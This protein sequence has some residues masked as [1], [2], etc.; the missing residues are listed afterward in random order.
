MNINI[1]NTLKPTLKALSAEDEKLMRERIVSMLAKVWPELEIVA[2][3]TD[4]L[5]ALTQWKKHRPQ[6]AFLD[7]RMP[8]KTGL[9]VAAEL[10]SEDDAPHIVFV[11]AYDEYAI[12]AFE[13]DA[14]D[15]L[16]KPVESERLLATV[17]RLKKRLQLVSETPPNTAPVLAS[18]NLLG[19]LESLLNRSDGNNT[20]INLASTSAT[21][22][23]PPKL[24]WI[25]ATLGNK[26]RLININ[27]AVF[28]QSDTKYT[29]IVT[30]ES[31]ALVRTPLKE[32]LEGLDEHEYW[33]IHRSTIVNANMIDRVEREGPEKLTLYL[34]NRTEKLAV[35]RQFFYLF[36][37]N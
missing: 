5:D 13:S 23:A 30:H 31:E 8:G 4:G 33:Q 26:T 18:G 29:R 9:E 21:N 11:T 7:I 10:A 36:K 19:L 32:L 15:Y 14:A 1:K 22:V 6:I 25:R 27:D 34:K 2:V 16:L 20:V 35:S 12:K 3:A 17:T 28:F 24:K 37:Q